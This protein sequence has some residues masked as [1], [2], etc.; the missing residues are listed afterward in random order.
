METAVCLSTLY[1]CQH[2]FQNLLFQ[3]GM[4]KSRNH[5]KTVSAKGWNKT[6]SVLMAHKEALWEKKCI[7]LGE[8][9]LEIC[10]PLLYGILF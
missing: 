9:A 5:I 10:T 8:L 6:C 4:L 3:A 1:A 2:F 7:R